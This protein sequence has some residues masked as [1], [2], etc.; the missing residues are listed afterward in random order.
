MDPIRLQTT[1]QVWLGP[2]DVMF[3]VLEHEEDAARL[4]PAGYLTRE[5]TRS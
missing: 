3:A 5:Q 1:K 2:T 4:P